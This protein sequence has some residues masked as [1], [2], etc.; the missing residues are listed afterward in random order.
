[1][2]YQVVMELTTYTGN[3]GKKAQARGTRK[4]HKKI[5]QPRAKERSRVCILYFSQ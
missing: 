3:D 5:A 4:K 1:M 2:D